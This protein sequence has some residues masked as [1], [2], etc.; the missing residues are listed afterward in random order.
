MARKKSSSGKAAGKIPRKLDLNSV[1]KETLKRVERTLTILEDFL[2]KWNNAG[3]APD[4][5]F[6]QIMKIK[7]FRDALANWKQDAMEAKS[8]ESYESRMRR[9]RD[10]VLICQTYS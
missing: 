6:P 2:A 4:D 1:E 8:D 3:T 9:L 5:M 10:F 7:K